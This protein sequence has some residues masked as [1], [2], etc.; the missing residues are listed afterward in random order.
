[1]AALVAALEGVDRGPD[2]VVVRE[3]GLGQRAD[4]RGRGLAGG[5]RGQ[6][7][8][9]RADQ[10][11]APA[12]KITRAPTIEMW[13]L[14]FSPSWNC[15]ANSFSASR[16]AMPPVAATLPAVKDESEVTSR[17]STSPECAMA[18]PFLSMT[19]TALALESRWSTSQMLLICCSSSSYITSWLDIAPWA[20]CQPE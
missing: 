5:E 19:S 10:A 16:E 7:L 18:C 11:L 17:C 2:Q 15:P 4:L 3:V 12:S 1:M 8:E 13:T 20:P 9:Q 14:V 6:D